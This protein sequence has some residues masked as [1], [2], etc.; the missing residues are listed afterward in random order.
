MTDRNAHM[1]GTERAQGAHKEREHRTYMYASLR[2]RTA[3]SA[4]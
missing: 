1:V 2:R 4:R 3:T